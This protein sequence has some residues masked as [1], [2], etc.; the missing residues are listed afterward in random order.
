MPRLPVRV[1]LYRMFPLIACSQIRK[2]GDDGSLAR[3]DGHGD[4]TV[5]RPIDLRGN[6]RLSH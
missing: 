5:T 4:E 1:G 6:L 2:E 3:E